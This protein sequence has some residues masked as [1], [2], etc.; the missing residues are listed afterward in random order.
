MGYKKLSGIYCFYNIINNKRYIGSSI[1]YN[2]RINGHLRTLD[3]KTHCN[4]HLQKAWNKYGKE[5]FKV[6][7]LEQ[8]QNV[9]LLQEKEQ[10]WIDFYKSYDFANGYNIL[11]EAFNSTGFKH[12]ESTKV[13]LSKIRKG[14]KQH[15]NTYKAIMTANTGAKR[16]EETKKKISKTHK[17]RKHSKE[18]IEKR[19][20]LLLGKNLKNKRRIVKCNMD[21][22]N[23]EIFETLK[24]CSESISM[25]MSNIRGICNGRVIQPKE[26][27]LMYE[28]YP[29]K[30]NRT[31][32]KMNLK[33]R[34][35]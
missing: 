9:L 24:N 25:S 22:N 21:F 27:I 3:S 14:K 10:Y 31:N 16:S 12:S 15:P 11:K 32:R 23:V 33:W 7:I 13:Y 20:L 29:I 19:R 5:N 17:G 35:I 28:H 18:S 30:W 8:V 1:S 4:N 26:F 34:K 6:I 2:S